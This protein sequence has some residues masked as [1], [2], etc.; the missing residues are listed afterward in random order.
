MKGINEG[1]MSLR[2]VSG[3]RGIPL[4]LTGVLDDDEVGGIQSGY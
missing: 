1:V 4:S 2:D 3:D